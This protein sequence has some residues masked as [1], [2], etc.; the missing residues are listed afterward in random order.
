MSDSGMGHPWAG[1]HGWWEWGGQ[2]AVSAREGL[3][4]VTQVFLEQHLQ[5]SL[6]CLTDVDECAQELDDCHA[7]ALCQNTPTSYKCSC[8]PGYRGE[9]R[10]CQGE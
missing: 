4:T 5:R 6:C 7:D 1:Q 8:K 2:R 9:G 3:G 10:H